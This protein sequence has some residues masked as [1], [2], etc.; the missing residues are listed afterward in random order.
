MRFNNFDI[1][2]VI[3]IGVLFLTAIYYTEIG[4]HDAPM[5][6]FYGI[7]I[8]FAFYLFKRVN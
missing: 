8:S 1:G 2:T 7:I 5:L 6:W 3:V 4:V